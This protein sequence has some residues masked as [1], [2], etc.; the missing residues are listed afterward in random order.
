MGIT[1]SKGQF[2]QKEG[3]RWSVFDN[4]F[5]GT[6]PLLGITGTKGISLQVYVGSVAK[7]GTGPMNVGQQ[8]IDKATRYHQEMPW[9]AFFRPP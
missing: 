6:I 4:G 8:E 5:P 9:G 3:S 2:C 1:F 7:A